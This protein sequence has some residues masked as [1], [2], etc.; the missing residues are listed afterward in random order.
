MLCGRTRRMASAYS[1]ALPNRRASPSAVSL[2]PAQLPTPRLRLRTV[3]ND[4]GFGPHPKSFRALTSACALRRAAADSMCPLCAAQC[5]AVAP[6]LAD[7]RGATCVHA[8]T[9]LRRAREGVPSDIPLVDVGLSREEPNQDVTVAHERGA[10]K[11]RPPIVPAPATHHAAGMHGR[12]QAR[13]RRAT[14]HEMTTWH[15]L[16]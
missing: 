2:R 11:R 8:G 16:R 9:R 14:H 5:N 15:R 13:M 6:L 4:T 1:A 12:P 10:E 7:V 3:L